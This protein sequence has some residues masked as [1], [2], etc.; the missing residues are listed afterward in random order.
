MI[1]EKKQKYVIM[2]HEEGEKLHIY[3]KIYWSI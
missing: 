2:W 3:Y 1:G